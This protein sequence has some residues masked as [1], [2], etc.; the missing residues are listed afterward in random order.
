MNALE[1][2]Q[3]LISYPTITPQECGIFECIKSLFPHFEI[4][5]CEKNGVKNLF[6]Y[7]VFNPLKE[8]EKKNMQKKSMKKKNMQK[9]SMKKKTTQKRKSSPCIFALQ[10][11]LMSCLLE[12][13]G[14]AIPL[15]PPL[16]RGFY[17]AVGRKT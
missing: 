8:H 3:K 7:R 14:K 5:E 16:K 11:I 2:T 1:I 15:S 9:K 17:T 4:L 10:G 12:I 6:L 13:I